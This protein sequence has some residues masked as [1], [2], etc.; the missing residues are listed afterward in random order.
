M[1]SFDTVDGFFALLV[2]IFM[3]QA[4]SYYQPVQGFIQKYPLY[5][6]TGLLILFFNRKRIINI[7]Y[8]K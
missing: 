8:K 4:L 1:I 3:F 2:G 7:F 6:V 5:I